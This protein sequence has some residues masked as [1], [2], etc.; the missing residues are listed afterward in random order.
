MCG[1][2]GVTWH[3]AFVRERL[4]SGEDHFSVREVFVDDGGLSWSADPIAPA[5]ETWQEL[6]DELAL[7]ANGAGRRVL[8]LTLDPPALVHPREVR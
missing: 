5:G 4:E 2:A 7:M 3:Y 8:D 6:A 1:W